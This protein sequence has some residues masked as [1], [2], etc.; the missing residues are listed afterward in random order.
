MPSYGQALYVFTLRLSRRRLLKS[1]LLAA[2]GLT[3]VT[4][5]GCEDEHAPSAT[6]RTPQGQGPTPQGR[7]VPMFDSGGV[8]IH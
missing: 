8:S 7:G 4:V 2:G 3:A 1:A 6:E 5:L